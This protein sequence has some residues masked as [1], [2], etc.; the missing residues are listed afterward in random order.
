MY[1]PIQQRRQL[2][3]TA[4]RGFRG[5]GDLTAIAQAI[6]TVEGWFPGSISYTNNNPGNLMYVGQAGATGADANGF[7]VFPNYQAGYQALLNQIQLDASRGETI[8]QFTAK[9]APASAGNDPG[10]YANTLAA[11]VGLSPSNSLSAAIA[12]TDTS[13]GLTLPDLPDLSSFLPTDSNGWMTWALIAA[14]ILGVV[15]L[16]QR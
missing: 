10:S 15:V 13:S 12:G 7:A 2:N 14:G 4:R 11:S 8:S 5:F 16:S 6:Q 1:L 9:Y 3:A